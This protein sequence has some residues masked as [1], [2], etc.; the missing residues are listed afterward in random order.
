MWNGIPF[1]NNSEMLKLRVLLKP[2]IKCRVTDPWGAEA[3]Q[4]DCTAL[5]SQ[6]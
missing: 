5:L 2:V 1:M 3:R 4:L 6:F